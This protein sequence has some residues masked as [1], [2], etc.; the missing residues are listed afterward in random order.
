MKLVMLL[1]NVWQTAVAVASLFFIPASVA[2]AHHADAPHSA[3]EPTGPTVVFDTS[4]GRVL[5]RLYTKEAPQTTAN[6]IALVQGYKDWTGSDGTVQH[7]KPFYD[8]LQVFGVTDGIGSG[9]RATFGLGN[10]GPATAAEKT[11]LD[12]DHAG[13]LA[14]V[15]PKG[16]EDSSKFQIIAHADLEKSRGAVVFGQCDDASLAVVAGISHE[17]LSTD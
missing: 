12:F 8:G 16:Q 14:M 3:A 5:C 10:A 17:L 2:Q 9:D 11:G 7:A 13:R 1:R 15:A 4:A 6:F